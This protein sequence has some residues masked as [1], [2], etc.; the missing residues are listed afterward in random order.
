MTIDPGT[1]AIVA[2]SL[3]LAKEPL[4][5]L[6]GPTL[7]YFGKELG[8]FAK[9]RTENIGRIFQKAIKKLGSKIDEPGQIH[10]KLLKSLILDGSFCDDELTAE[11]YGGVLASSRSG[12]NRDAAAQHI[13][14][15]SL[16]S[17]PI[18][19]ELI[20]LSTQS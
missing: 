8:S 6:L 18:K 4:N 13:L 1:A 20:S 15:K 2:S 16:V 17:Q 12:V 3:L 5:K 19:S 10:P 9:K 11:Y 14:T 7:D